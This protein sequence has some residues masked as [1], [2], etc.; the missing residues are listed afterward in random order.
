VIVAT[1][2]GSAL[3]GLCQLLGL[4]A[5]PLLL[6]PESLRMNRREDIFDA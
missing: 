6:L 1:V 2:R 3:R 4:R 5:Q